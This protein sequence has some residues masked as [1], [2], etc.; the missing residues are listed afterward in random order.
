M[1]IKNHSYL[2]D[3][4]L[5]QLLELTESSINDE[6]TFTRD[7]SSEDQAKWNKK[8]TSLKNKEFSS[9]KKLA[10]F[11]YGLFKPSV[12]MINII[13]I[14]KRGINQVIN[15]LFN[16]KT[17][18][19][20]SSLIRQDTEHDISNVEAIIDKLNT[21]NK[22]SKV[23]KNMNE[24][25]SLKKVSSKDVVLNLNKLIEIGN[26]FI[27]MEFLFESDWNDNSDYPDFLDDTTPDVNPMDDISF[28]V[29]D[30]VN[31]I[32]FS[33]IDVVETKRKNINIKDILYNKKHTTKVVNYLS[34]FLDS[35]KEFKTIPYGYGVLLF[36]LSLS[37]I[38]KKVF[39]DDSDL[40]KE[41]DDVYNFFEY[42]K[43]KRTY[44]GNVAAHIRWLIR[45]NNLGLLSDNEFFNVDQ[46]TVIADIEKAIGYFKASSSLWD[47]HKKEHKYIDAKKIFKKAG[48]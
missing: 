39:K 21:N 26:K 22:I 17:P 30:E 41:L 19:S 15:N 48:E 13:I 45:F 42:T 3:V 24:I 44:V 18:S 6:Y 4:R 43:K 16:G 25:S 35:V 40:I 36:S 47:G 32:S 37:E 9:K 34:S 1:N 38:L 31:N 5:N 11:L 2:L 23:L 28:D 10:G 14:R 20:I 27:E 12:E 46:N 7:S 33:D 8:R 29:N